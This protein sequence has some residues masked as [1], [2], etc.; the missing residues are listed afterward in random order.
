VLAAA[1]GIAVAVGVR[2]GT[3][4]VPAG[5]PATGSTR[6]PSPDVTAVFTVAPVTVHAAASRHVIDASSDEGDVVVAPG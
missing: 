2:P 4:R 5:P 6:G 3:S 1:A